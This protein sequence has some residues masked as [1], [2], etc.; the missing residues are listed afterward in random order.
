MT[1]LGRMYGMLMGYDRAGLLRMFRNATF[2]AIAKSVLWPLSL[3]VQWESGFDCAIQIEN[4]LVDRYMANDNFYRL[5]QIDARIKDPE[6][7]SI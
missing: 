4:N 7:V 1:V 2:C 3:Y 5:S 6:C